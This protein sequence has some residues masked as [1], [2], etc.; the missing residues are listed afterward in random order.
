MTTL[1]RIPAHEAHVLRVFAVDEAPDAPVEDQAVLEALGA[2]EIKTA[3][4][5]LFDVSDLQD[6]PLSDYLAEGHGIPRNQLEPMRLQLNGLRGRVLL[7]PSR[8]FDGRA[9]EM[10]PHAPLRMIG[11][12]SEEVPPV[13]FVPLPAGGAQGVITLKPDKAPQR[14]RAARWLALGF[15]ALLALV[16][17]LVISLA[18]MP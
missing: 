16:L 2:E 9:Q 5:E 4:V 7:L 17:A 11:R 10:R 13:S 15:F 18:V 14:Q 8:A 3:E 6:L 1:L 12:F